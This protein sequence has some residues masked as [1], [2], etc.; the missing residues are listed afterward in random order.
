MK[1][2]HEKVDGGNNFVFEVESEE[3]ERILKIFSNCMSKRFIDR[4][5]ITVFNSKSI[6]YALGDE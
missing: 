4:G 1:L 2:K 3:E 6:I 5:N